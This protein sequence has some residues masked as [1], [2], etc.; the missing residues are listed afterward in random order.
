MKF[1][2]KEK[3]PEKIHLAIRSCQHLLERVCLPIKKI[4]E[5]LIVLLHV[6]ID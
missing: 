6:I 2:E 1:C 3:H 5:V 4:H